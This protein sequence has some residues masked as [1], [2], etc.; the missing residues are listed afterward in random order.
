[1]LER[2]N[3][4]KF[5][6]S[7]VFFDKVKD[8]T[9]NMETFFPNLVHFFLQIFDIFVVWANDRKFKPNYVFFGKKIYVLK[10]KLSQAT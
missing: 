2:R 9:E 8:T 5:K 3:E 4:G 10:I 1:M 7:Y 6:P